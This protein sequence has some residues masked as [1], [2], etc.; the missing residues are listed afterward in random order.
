[1]RLTIIKKTPLNIK[2]ESSSFFYGGLIGLI[3]FI[4]IYGI[5]PLCVTK[6]DWLLGKM[7][8]TQ[9]YLGWEFY[10]KAP[11]SFP[12][13]LYNT[14]SYPDYTSIVF[15]DSI[16]LI[17][18]LL[19]PLSPILPNEFQFFG[20]YVFFMFFLQGGISALII[21]KLTYNFA[22]S[23]VASVFFVLSTPFIW[24]VFSHTSLTAHF[25]LLLCLLI[26]LC[27]NNLLKKSPLKAIMGWS[28]ILF[29]SVSIHFYF[30]P[31]TFVFLLSYLTNNFI[32]YKNIKQEV[33][34]LII[35]L[36]IALFSLFLYGGFSSEVTPIN[37]ANSGGLGFFSANINTFYNPIFDN[38]NSCSLF[39][40]PQVLNISNS[41]EGQYEGFSYLGLGIIIICIIDVI[42]FLTNKHIRRKIISII[43]KHIVLVIILLI[44]SLLYFLFS[45]SPKI[46][47]GN[48]LL[49]EVKTPTLVNEIWSIFKS[50][51]RFIWP[52]YYI[53][54]IGSIYI[55]Y[56]SLYHLNKKL[57]YVLFAICFS[58]QLADLSL[59]LTGEKE[60]KLSSIF[61]ESNHFKQKD[62]IFKTKKHLLFCNDFNIVKH[63][64]LL[65]L[66]H[67]NNVTLNTFY[68]SRSIEYYSEKKQK[69][70]LI[71]INSNNDDCIYVLSNDFIKTIDTTKLNKLYLL[72]NDYVLLY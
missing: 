20:I 9:N 54:L 3:I 57:L 1:M 46:T 27:Y 23:L 44:T 11:W 26:I 58:I 38:K 17:S 35:P 7:D 71:K 21:R 18:V 62:N 36:S 2:K 69:E 48:R 14:L 67:K 28:L 66:A 43:S 5:E 51:G 45:I 60:R 19:K 56:I 32:S 30:F 33:L 29:L 16:P 41:T 25:L 34:C 40:S 61:I 55:F 63:C 24:R 6:V 47:V 8:I 42:L 22:F 59:W 52:V 31:I 4:C 72:T 13:G 37:A 15:T 64:E 12:I 70:A 50:T 68:F 10:R 53:I 49:Y 65:T 39:I